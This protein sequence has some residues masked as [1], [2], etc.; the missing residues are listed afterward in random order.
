MQI[1]ISNDY[2]FKCNFIKDIGYS[3]AMNLKP[4]EMPIAYSNIKTTQIQK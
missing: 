3:M 1:H 4:L 2:F